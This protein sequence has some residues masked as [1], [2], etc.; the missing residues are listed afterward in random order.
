MNDLELHAWILFVDV[1]KNFLGKYRAENY[2]EL[3]E[4]LFK[5]L[6]DII[7]NIK[8]YFLRSHL[9]KFADNCSDVSDE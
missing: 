2:K 8:V 5:S 3:M 4:K 1:M 9:N 6:Q 7:A